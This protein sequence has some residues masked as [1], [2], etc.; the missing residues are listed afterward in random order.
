MSEKRSPALGVSKHTELTDKEVEDIIDHA[1][2]SI[3]P[4][5][6]RAIDAPADGEAPTYDSVTEKFE[7]A[8]GGAAGWELVEEITLAEGANFVTFSGLD[9]DDAKFYRL[10]ICARGEGPGLSAVYMFFNGDEVQTNYWSQILAASGEGVDAYRQ[11]NAML[12][13]IRP[14][15]TMM[16]D[17]L[18]S[19]AGARPCASANFGPYIDGMGTS[20]CTGCVGWV[21]SANVTQIKLWGN[22]IMGNSFAAG[23]RFV[24]FKVSA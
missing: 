10:L 13:Q 9:L 16:R 1:A 3:T 17:V 15:Y 23:S 8:P 11:N 5:K 22:A 20:A 6:L 21:T 2:D 12:S 7:W 4:A 18:I 14:S 19:R 24:L